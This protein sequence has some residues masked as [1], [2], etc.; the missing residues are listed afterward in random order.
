MELGRF[1]LYHACQ[2]SREIRTDRRKYSGCR[3]GIFGSA[4]SLR[5][6]KDAS[7]VHHAPQQS[8]LVTYKTSLG[9]GTSFPLVFLI[10]NHSSRNSYFVN[11]VLGRQIQTDGVA[12]TDNCFTIIAPEPS[13]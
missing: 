1:D 4:Q 5:T 9:T 2:V 13:N 8:A 7:L 3:C 11:Y 6:V 10:R 12:L